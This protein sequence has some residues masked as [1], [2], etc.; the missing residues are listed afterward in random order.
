MKTSTFVLAGVAVFGG[1]FGALRA[2]DYLQHRASSSGMVAFNDPS[3]TFKT[4]EYEPGGTVQAAPFDFRA[5]S[6]KVN[7]SVVSVDQY[8]QLPTSSGFWG[9]DDGG[10]TV[11]RET[12][13]GSGVIL[14][15]SGIV[16]TNNHVV[17]GSSRLVVHLS[18]GRTA[19]A[20]LLG[21]DQ[22][23]DLAV[24]KIDL[25]NITP[26]E[27]G[28]NSQVEVGE[29]VLAVGNPLG[30]ANTVSVGVVSSLKRDLPVGVEGMTNAIQTDAAIN[31][32]N[33]GGA[34]CDAQGRLIGINAAIASGNG[35]SVGIGFA[36]PVDRVKDVVQQIVKNG[37]VRYAGLG[38][39][40]DPRLEGI[41]ASPD[42]RQQLAEQTGAQNVPEK[43]V[44]VGSA[45]GAAAQAGIQPYDVLLSIDG[46]E[47]ANKFDLN[48]AL[49]DKKPG[50][51]AAVKFWD[52]GQ[53]KTVDVTLQELQPQRNL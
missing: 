33:S 7:P 17:E 20:K 16:V 50:D 3:A 6:K 31:P 18:D 24:L 46:K 45:Q 42:A 25:P 51:K 11:E 10:R 38:V 32:G 4:A 9:D 35:G 36:I 5:A 39:G 1:V 53:T 19:N 27:T 48:K 29:W 14:T 2:N 43:G 34:L 37:Y 22:R 15:D 47:V 13:Q 52:K 8:R 21:R 44:I 12:G 41:L 26:I 28:A 23:S 30:F 49:G 40:L